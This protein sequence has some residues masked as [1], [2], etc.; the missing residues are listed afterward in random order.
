MRYG[1]WTSKDTDGKPHTENVTLKENNSLS[2]QR[3][4]DDVKTFLS[5]EYYEIISG[6]SSQI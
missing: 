4:G 5:T 1:I 3:R 6:R 2:K